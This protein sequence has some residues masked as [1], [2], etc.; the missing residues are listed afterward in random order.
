MQRD[1]EVEPAAQHLHEDGLEE[2]FG[3]QL[4]VV[5]EAP[6]LLQGRV[7]RRRRAGLGKRDHA[8]DVEHE[9]RIVGHGR[10]VTQAMR[11]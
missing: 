6:V 11:P 5:T 7:P 3:R 1:V 2:E 9:N 10:M 4:L 8:V